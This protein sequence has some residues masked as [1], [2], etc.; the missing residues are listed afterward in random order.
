MCYYGKFFKPQQDTASARGPSL[1]VSKRQVAHC[2]RSTKRIDLHSMTGRWNAVFF[3]TTGKIRWHLG[4]RLEI[5]WKFVCHQRVNQ[6][7]ILDSLNTDT[8]TSVSGVFPTNCIQ[9]DILKRLVKQKQNPFEHPTATCLFP[10]PWSPHIQHVPLR[11]QSAV[12]EGLC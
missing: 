9:T 1:S 6:I 8:N 7:I 10:Q 12:F 11:H 5:L 2:P 3:S 4:K